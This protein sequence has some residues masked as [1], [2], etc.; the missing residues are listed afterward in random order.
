MADRKAR[1]ILI[2]EDHE[3]CREA[4]EACIQEY[5]TDAKAIGISTIRE[6]KAALNQIKTC[7]LLILDLG[8]SDSSGV[9][10]FSQ[11]REGWP[12]LP[13]LILSAEEDLQLQA[14]VKS[15]G[16]AGFMTKTHSMQQI[17]DAI[18]AVLDGGTAFNRIVDAIDSDAL[19]A[20]LARFR[21]LTEAQ[22]R[23]LKAM[24]DGALNKQIAFELGISEITVKFHVKNI[25]ATLQVPNR[26]TAVME[27]R[28]IQKYL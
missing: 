7:D 18:T 15:L 5:V 23:V 12:H 11:I 14:I 13:V 22:R 8:L 26:T 28:D 19:A 1:T 9:S 17:R 25:L 3:F 24:M 20:R 2:V 10:T 16:A 4:I 27:F 21:S 6:A